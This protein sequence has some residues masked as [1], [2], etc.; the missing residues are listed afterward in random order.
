MGEVRGC[1]PRRR[2]GDGESCGLSCYEVEWAKCTRRER[3]R[4]KA[5]IRRHSIA[6]GSW[7]ERTAGAHVHARP[8]QPPPSRCATSRASS[9]RCLPGLHGITHAA[10]GGF[11]S[12]QVHWAGR[13]AWPTTMAA[14]HIR[15]RG[16]V[17]Y[18][19]ALR[20][21]LIEGTAPF[22][23]DPLGACGFERRGSST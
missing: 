23:G 16:S 22:D 1:V 11:R 12:N 3:R 4:G 13:A 20:G 5:V 7:Q 19:V 17:M 9:V 15:R 18:K 14:K 21:G 6:G 2:H 10:A 8:G